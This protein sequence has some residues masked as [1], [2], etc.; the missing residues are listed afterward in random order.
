MKAK[1][2][3]PAA[4]GVSSILDGFSGDNHGLGL[5]FDAVDIGLQEKQD[6][7]AVTAWSRLFQDKSDT[8]ADGGMIWIPSGLDLGLGLDL[9]YTDNSAAGDMS[10]LPPTTMTMM[11]ET[12]AAGTTS[13]GDEIFLSPSTG[14]MQ[15]LFDHGGYLSACSHLDNTSAPHQAKGNS[16]I[17]E[18]PLSA[19]SS[20]DFVIPGFL[21]FHAS[22][23]AS[24][25][26]AS[27]TSVYQDEE[28]AVDDVMNGRPV[29][30]IV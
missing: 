22:A 29:E 12:T 27:D 5:G 14:I 10:F 2:K 28:V 7:D 18:P 17:E 8:N 25:C 9:G 26:D 4:G 15:T 23:S 13:A 21:D 3:S 1:G 30:P 20:S 19:I 11:P 24:S 16:G 6:D